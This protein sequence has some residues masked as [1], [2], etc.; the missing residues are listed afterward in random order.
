MLPKYKEALDKIANES[1][2]FAN[3][4]KEAFAIVVEVLESK[5]IEKLKEAKELIKGNT[6]KESKI[7]MKAIETLALF[8]PEAKDLRQVVALIKVN[9]E[10]SRI[11]DYVKSQINIL[12][13]EIINEDVF[14]TDG[15]RVAFYKST[16]KALDHSVALIKATDGTLSDL[17]RE[18]TIEESKCDDFVSILEKNIITSICANEIET[19][20]VVARLNSVRKLERISDRC[21]NIAKLMKFAIEG[22]KL[23]L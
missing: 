19:E 18:I 15:T 3:S 8:S 9:G 20:F 11:A 23:K 12:M 7:D 13:H 5:D 4:I 16:L 14:G 1:H 6:K 10:F 2:D 22:G 17:I 21:V